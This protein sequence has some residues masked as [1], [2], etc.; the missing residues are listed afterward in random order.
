[1]AAA[2]PEHLREAIELARASVAAGGGPFAALVLRD[3]AVVSRGSNRVTLEC[4]PTAH[5]EVAA[6]R[7]AGRA[8]GTHDLSG[9]VLVASCEP[10]PMCLGAALWARVERVVYAAT[11]DDAAAAGFDDARFHAALGGR[12]S[13]ALMP[14]EHSS[15]PERCAPFEDWLALADRRPY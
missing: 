11:R 9:C 2:D 14:L 5:A 7:A 12:A 13:G 1:M 3:G 4:D 10:C 6:L 15:L 8:L